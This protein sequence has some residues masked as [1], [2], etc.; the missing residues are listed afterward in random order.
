LRDWQAR[1]RA[2]LSVLNSI[3]AQIQ[4]YL[5][6]MALINVLIAGATWAVL[7]YVGLE[8]AIPGCARGDTA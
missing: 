7:A 3:N 4:R 6:R 5:A 8:H 1:R 2:A